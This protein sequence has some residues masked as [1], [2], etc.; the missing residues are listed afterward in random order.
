MRIATLSAALGLVLCVGAG[1][2]DDQAKPSTHTVKME[3]MR[4][5]PDELTVAVGE[6]IVWVNEDLVPHTATSRAGRFDS[7]EIEAGKSWRHT[8]SRRG[9]FP[10]V[11]TLHRKMKGILHVR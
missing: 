2:A 11:C 6:T 1:P 8:F 7:N 3:G 9:D 5:H 4:F 10:Y